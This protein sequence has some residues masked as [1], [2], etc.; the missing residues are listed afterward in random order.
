MNK[1]D[2]SYTPIESAGTD[3]EFLDDLAPSLSITEAAKMTKKFIKGLPNDM[4]DIDLGT[5]L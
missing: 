5:G 4:T 2:N 1:T 3:V